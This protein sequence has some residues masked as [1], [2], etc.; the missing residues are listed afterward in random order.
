MIWALVIIAGLA[1]VLAACG[2]GESEISL[3]PTEIDFGE[4]TNGE[5]R[6]AE[7]IVS[8]PGGSDLLIEAVSTSCGCTKAEINPGVIPP[9][10]TGTLVVSFDSGAHGPEET[11]PVER[12]VFIASNDPVHPEIQL[13]ITAN[14]LPRP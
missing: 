5:V 12:Q 13:L 8:N 9:G 1:A 10:G 3:Q 2:G 4:V 6:T 14:I 7:A 11:G